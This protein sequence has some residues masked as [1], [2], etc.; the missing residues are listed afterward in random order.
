MINIS[1]FTLHVHVKEIL[2][3]QLIEIIIFLLCHKEH[4]SPYLVV[5]NRTKGKE[6]P[7]QL[8]IHIQ[9]IYREIYLHIINI[10]YTHPHTRVAMVRHFYCT[11]TILELN[12]SYNNR[13]I[14][15]FVQL[16]VCQSVSIIF[17]E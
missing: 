5:Q 15:H 12:T 10:V 6:I 7:N 4:S 9:T 8:L 2:V 14:F 17:T 3:N 11:V 16:I 13:L 1:T